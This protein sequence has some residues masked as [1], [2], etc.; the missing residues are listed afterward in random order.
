MPLLD[1][2]QDSGGEIEAGEQLWLN[3]QLVDAAFRQ[4]TGKPCFRSLNVC[5]DAVLVSDA[6]KQFKIAAT[7]APAA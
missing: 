2:A 5:F 6:G 7:P 1:A 4:A 3:R